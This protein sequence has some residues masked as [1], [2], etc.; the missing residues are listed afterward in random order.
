MVLAFVN[1]ESVLALTRPA[2]DASYYILTTNTGTLFNLGHSQGVYDATHGN[3]DSDVVL[4]FG[5]QN[6]TNTG[7]KL[8]KTTTIVSYATDESLAESFAAGYY[9]G[10]GSDLTSVVTM[11]IGTNN[12]YYQVSSTGGSTWASVVNAVHSWVA[13]SGYASQVDVI[14]ANDMEEPDYD[15]FSPTQAWVNGYWTSY[16]YFNYGSA[17]GC[18]QFTHTNSPACDNGWTQDN[19]WWVSYGAVPAYATPEIYNQGQAN[20]WGQIKQWKS[21]SFEGPLDE[22]PLDTSTFTAAQ[23]WN[24]LAAAE[25]SAP[26]SASLE[27]HNA[28]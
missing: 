20:E 18:P 7:T 8:P 1:V 2:T 5:G 21:M 13:S 22:Y 17:D 26:M 4:D 6:S 19:V 10:T 23:A 14:G 11:A 27:I 28:T 16:I 3:I 15:T 25:G 9:N 12:S 24:A